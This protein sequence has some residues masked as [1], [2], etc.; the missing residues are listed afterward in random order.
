M[1]RAGDAAPGGGLRRM[2]TSTL[3]RDL[4]ASFSRTIY[5]FFFFKG[6]VERKRPSVSLQRTMFFVAVSPGSRAGAQAWRFVQ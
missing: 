3:K 5:V 1:G 6:H 4:G 2:L